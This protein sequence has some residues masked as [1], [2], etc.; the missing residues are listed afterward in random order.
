MDALLRFG[1]EPQDESY[2]GVKTLYQVDASLSNASVISTGASII[3]GP[4]AP[5]DGEELFLSLVGYDQPSLLYNAIRD[6]HEHLSGHQLSHIPSFGGIKEIRLG[7]A[8]LM[9]DRLS[10]E[11]YDFAYGSAIRVSAFKIER[12]VNIVGPGIYHCGDRELFDIL[13]SLSRSLDIPT[14]ERTQLDNTLTREFF[15]QHGAKFTPLA[16]GTVASSNQCSSFFFC[17]FRQCLQCYHRF[18]TRTF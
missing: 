8:D 6:H 5:F 17:R 3:N 15:P 10:F 14:S 12:I 9:L 4:K 18:K 7:P 13:I 2:F 16:L 11:A 1:L